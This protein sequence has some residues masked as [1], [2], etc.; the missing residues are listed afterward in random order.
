MWW[1]GLLVFLASLTGCGSSPEQ[2]AQLTELLE[3]SPSLTVA[4]SISATQ[5]AEPELTTT[6][7]PSTTQA[8]GLDWTQITLP[9][10]MK[11]Y[12][13]YSWQQAGQWYFT[14]I[15][16]T[17]RMKAFEE[18]TSLENSLTPD[19]W[20]KLTVQGAEQAARLLARLQP[21][22]EVFW[23][24]MEWPD[25]STPT[26]AP[27]LTYPPAEV[28]QMLKTAATAAGIKLTLAIP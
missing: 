1:I 2:K 28:R 20:V 21:G 22:S 7:E 25:N 8:P 12:E 13:F 10:S 5:P 27:F 9:M 15:T 14:L 26:S 11:G 19:G 24:G 3:P 17:N 6:P 23:A 16:G 18:I 4:G